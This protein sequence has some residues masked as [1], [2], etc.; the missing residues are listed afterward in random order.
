MQAEE[1][2]KKF[3]QRE[4]LVDTEYEAWAFGGES[5]KLGSLTV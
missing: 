1:M 4:G 5:D 2:W 3:A